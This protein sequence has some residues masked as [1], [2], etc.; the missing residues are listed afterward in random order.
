MKDFLVFLAIIVFF[1][2]FLQKE[3]IAEEMLTWEDCVREARENHPDLISAAQRVKQAKA[4]K[5]IALSDILPQVSGTMIGK[6]KETY[7]GEDS[8]ILDTYSYSLTGEQ[9]LFDGFKTSAEVSLYYKEMKAS[10]HN[11][12]VVSSN[13]RLDLREVFV[14]LLKTQELI[15]LTKEIAERRKQNLELVKLMYEGGREHKG[16]L[17]TAEAEYAEANF[18]VAQAERNLIL[19]Q[20]QLMV[21]LGR[22]KMMP[23][24]AKG[25]F[26]TANIY[27]EKPDLEDLTRKNPLLKELIALRESAEFSLKS[28]EAD[29]FPKVFLDTSVGKTDT[30]WPPRDE[31]WYLGMRL[32]VPIFEGGSRIAEVVKA[33]AAAK[34]AKA[35]ERSGY[36]NVVF[37]LEEKWKDLQDAIDKVSVR[38]KFLEATEERSKIA[39]AQYSIGHVTFND[40]IIIE[41]ELVSAKKSY[42]DAQADLLIAEADW[43]QAKGGTLEYEE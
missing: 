36:N 41:D 10:Q 28:E 20:R 5:D 34:E 24:R 40:W 9:L 14:G 16:S 6:R 3:A 37:V 29:F 15:S 35:D 26:K 2:S 7:S 18:E 17:L 21:E 33:R 12:A 27:A 23:V 25:E 43:I 42:L 13:I 22:E 31:E 11:Y 19:V 39:S 30:S 8:T 38:Q 1:V 32:T 4:D